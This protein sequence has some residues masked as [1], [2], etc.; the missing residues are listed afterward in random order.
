MITL[1]NAIAS[2]FRSN[3]N[4][5]GSGVIVGIEDV[6]TYAYHPVQLPSPHWV[7]IHCMVM[8]GHGVG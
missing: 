6:T 4:F 8:I 1:I 2:G 5:Y 7:Y 3:T